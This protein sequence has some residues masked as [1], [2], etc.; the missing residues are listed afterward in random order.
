[1]IR[2]ASSLQPSVVYK[3]LSV[4]T[5]VSTHNEDNKVSEVSD[6]KTDDLK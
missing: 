2:F 4:T 3:V 5:V 1:V 6:W